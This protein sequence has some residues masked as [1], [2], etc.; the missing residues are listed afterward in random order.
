MS[1]YTWA[2]FQRMEN[3]PDYGLCPDPECDAGYL[4]PLDLGDEWVLACVECRRIVEAANVQ[5]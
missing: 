2:N 3:P 5:A 1:D 4:E